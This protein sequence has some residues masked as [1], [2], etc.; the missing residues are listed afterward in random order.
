M[1]FH[2]YIKKL[3]KL[4]YKKKCLRIFSQGFKMQI[5]GTPLYEVKGSFD[6]I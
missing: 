4:F 6:K 3:S 2:G 5:D 1:C